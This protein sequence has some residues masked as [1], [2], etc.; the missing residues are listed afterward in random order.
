MKL[1][2]NGWRI[3][4][5]RTGIGRYLV[6]VVGRWTKDFVGDL[7]QE[8]TFYTPHPIDRHVIPIPDNIRIRVL[9]PPWRLLVWENLRLGPSTQDTILWGP[10]YSRPLLSR[11]GS[12]VTTHDATQHL[13]PDMFPKIVKYVHSPLYRW[14]AKH[15]VLVITSNEASRRDI[16]EHMGVPIEEIHVVHLAP[17]E[18]FKHA[19]DPQRDVEIRRRYL[20]V[21]D[22]YFLFVGKMTGRRNIPL[23]LEAFAKFKR[24]SRSAHRLLLVG[25]KSHEEALSKK[26]DQLGIS[27]DVFHSGFVSDEDLNHIYNAA[28]AF[29]MPSIYETVS[30]P[31]MESQATATPVIAVDTAGS[32]ELT[33]GEALLLPEFN[34]PYAAAA[35]SKIASD[36]GFRAELGQRGH[37]NSKRF[38]WDRTARETLELLHRA[39]KMRS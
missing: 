14:S 5:K 11:S 19:P 26:L 1:G 23:L 28:E 7:F 18:V 17:D 25:L 10:S 21:S 4:G 8:I 33:G 2:I 9:S 20:G 16:S 32:R 34:V 37:K 6:N 36:A 31:L 30:F 38:S 29:V 12:V 24:D 3:H 22:P 15:S 27:D 35:M 39:A 13:Y